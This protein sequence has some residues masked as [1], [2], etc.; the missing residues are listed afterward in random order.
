MSGIGTK[1]DSIRP[2]A[3]SPS[4]SQAKIESLDMEKEEK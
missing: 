2:L 3:F 4:L 1:I